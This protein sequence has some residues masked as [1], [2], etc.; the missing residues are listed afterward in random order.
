MKYFIGIDDSG[1]GPVI[2]PMVL[3]GILADEKQI[4]ILKELGAK[5]SKMITPRRR[6]LLAKRIKKFI[7]AHYII[8]IPAQ[9][10]DHQLNSGIN[11]N[12]VEAIK[13]A[14]IINLLMKKVD[15]LKLKEVEIIID[16][17]SVNRES[18]KDYLM[19]HI[20][21]NKNVKINMRCEHKADVNH[22]IV[23]A[24]SILG[25]VTRDAEIEKIKIKY[26]IECGS[27]YPADPLCKKF[28]REQGDEFAELGIVRKTWQTWKNHVNK[29]T[30]KRLKDF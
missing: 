30:Q 1:R 20:I 16:C 5:D 10:I 24:A 14:E 27:G 6:E 15:E 19:K 7:S 29:K 12:K 28:L 23:S 21:E 25:K 8:K 3:A 18:W 26:G 13:A 22:A 11:L 17:P 9:E 4:K 2:G